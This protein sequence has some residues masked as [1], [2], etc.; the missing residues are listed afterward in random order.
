MNTT[1][2]KDIIRTLVKA[3]HV[4]LAKEFARSRGYGVHAGP[5]DRRPLFGALLALNMEMNWR[6]SGGLSRLLNTGSREEMAVQKDWAKIVSAWQGSKRAY[7]SPAR[8]KKFKDLLYAAVDTKFKG[9]RPEDIDA[10]WKRARIDEKL[11]QD[12]KTLRDQKKA[13]KTS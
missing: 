7:P 8:I 3:G 6:M 1:H 2:E 10:A 5:L 12:R 13:S 4:P 11:D 9:Y